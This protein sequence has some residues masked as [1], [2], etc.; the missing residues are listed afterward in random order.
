MV[1]GPAVPDVGFDGIDLLAHLGLF[2]AWGA[3]VVWEWAPR[4]WALLVVGVAF[5]VGTEALQTVAIQRTFSWSDIA[6]D[7]VGITVGA[8]LALLVRRHRLLQA[9]EQG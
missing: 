3:A 5:A 2:G 4:W 7:L 8:G 1:P 6:A 9:A